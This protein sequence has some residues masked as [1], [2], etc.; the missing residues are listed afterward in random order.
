[1]DNLPPFEIRDFQ[2]DLRRNCAREIYSAPHE[3]M[4]SISAAE[5]RPL[6]ALAIA[7]VLTLFSGC[8]RQDNSY[9]V[10][11]LPEVRVANPV[12]RQITSYVEGTGRTAPV[13]SAQLVARVSGF[14]TTIHY[15]DGSPVR[16]DST[17][18]TIEPEPYR[19]KLEQA[20][21]IQAAALATLKQARA[22]YERQAELATRQIASRA[23]LENATANR[24]AAQARLKQAEVD[25]DQAALSLAYTDIKA[26]FDGIVTAHQ[27]SVGELVGATGPT[28]LARIIDIDK[29]YVTFNINEQTVLRLYQQ[30]KRLGMTLDNLR[31]TPVEVALQNESSYPH[32]G[33]LDYVAPMVSEE[34]G[35]LTVRAIL[36][37]QNRALLPGYFVRIR[38]PQQQQNALLI[39]EA[40]L[41]SDQSS[42]YVLVL[43]LD[44]VVEQRKVDIGPKIG[45]F[46]VVEA[47]LSPD[48]RLIIRGIARA[49]PGQKVIPKLEEGASD[50]DSFP[51][52]GKR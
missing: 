18:F 28:Q 27:V 13:N 31:T 42:R 37:N 51:E 5:R 46:R 41:G 3:V 15:R 35:T 26:P 29:I 24:D 43:S 10:P 8:E 48:D 20:R 38:I 2:T 52:R 47:G 9:I 25:V 17:L 22:D 30:F 14:L 16:R 11:P 49:I 33:V 44:N 45:E 36:P 39:P 21:A 32:K 1:M 7:A 40:A 19:L 23:A 4:I 50:G 6:T 12:Q 34:T